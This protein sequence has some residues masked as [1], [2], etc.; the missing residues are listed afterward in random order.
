MIDANKLRALDARATSAPWQ[1]YSEPDVGLPYSL[2]SG[3]PMQ[4]GF[5]PLEPLF[6]ADIDLMVLLRN[7]VPDILAL[8]EEVRVLR[9]SVLELVAPL[10]RASGQMIKEGRTL[11][12]DAEAVLDRA[13]AALALGACDHG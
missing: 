10:E 3:T 2:F 13:H 9:A 12:E 4:S 5:G 1:G 11:N 7:A 8:T 6:G